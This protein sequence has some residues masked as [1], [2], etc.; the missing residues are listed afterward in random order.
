M[1]EIGFNI[2]KIRA[3][4]KLNQSQFAELFGVKRANI[5]SYEEQRAEPKLDLIIAISDYFKISVDSLVRKKLSVNEILHFPNHEKAMAQHT[6]PKIIDGE[7]KILRGFCEGG[8]IKNTDLIYQN[9][10]TK[11]I[12]FGIYDE[13]LVFLTKKNKGDRYPFLGAVIESDRVYVGVLTFNKELNKIVVAN[14]K[15]INEIEVA[16]ESLKIYKSSGF[17]SSSLRYTKE[18][19]L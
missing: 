5:G 16:K 8:F 2:K 12:S 10:G 4:K 9:K 14:N 13:D 18:F 7:N 6:Q 15:E 1:T 11:L 3:V 19:L 17:Y